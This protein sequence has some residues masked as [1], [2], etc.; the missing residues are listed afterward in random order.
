MN[1]LTRS[2]IQTLLRHR[3]IALKKRWGQNFLVSENVL[4][5]IVEVIRKLAQEL[6]P[7][8]PPSEIWEIGPGLGALT[9]RITPIARHLRLFE[10]DRALIR[11][12][13]ET[14]QHP[15]YS[16]S[17]GDA[18]DNMRAQW[19]C[20]TRPHLVVGNLPYRSATALLVACAWAPEPPPG[21]AFL[22]QREIAERLCA[23][24]H[25]RTYSPLSVALQS[26]YHL[27][28][29]FGV[30]REAFFPT[31][32]VDSLFL[33]GTRLP[34]Y[35][36]LHRPQLERI[37]RASFASRRATLRNNLRR[38]TT[39]KPCIPEE[40]L[41]GARVATIDLERRAETLSTKEFAHLATWLFK[42]QQSVE[43]S[44]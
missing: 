36:R 9:S 42:H 11:Y 31:P 21:I 12:L 17:A 29:L 22:V 27:T 2:E 40:A 34:E 32:R 28:P 25:T 4:G 23:R 6:S 14:V 43:N 8:S 19:R 16:L 39:L 3:G 33:V 20:G 5:R 37:T 10:I 15:E 35:T 7:T 38:A 26:H 24:P 1:T 18:L 41:L 13:E 30:A 44:D